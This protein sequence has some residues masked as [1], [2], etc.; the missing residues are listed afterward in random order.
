M[1]NVTQNV[2]AESGRRVSADFGYTNL[3]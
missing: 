3:Q 2:T 1:V